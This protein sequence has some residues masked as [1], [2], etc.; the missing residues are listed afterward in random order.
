[1]IAKDAA[2]DKVAAKEQK[3]RDKANKAETLRLDAVAHDAEAK[4]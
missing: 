1:L 2:E 4:E 3:E